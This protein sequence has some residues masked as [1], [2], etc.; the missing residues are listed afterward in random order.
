MDKIYNVG[1]IGGGVSGVVTALHLANSGIDS[2]LFE[3]KSSVV[4]GP[5]FCHL[6]AGGNLYP[7]ISD[8]ERRKLMKQSIAMARMFPQSIDQRPTFI[9]VP[10]TEKIETGIIEQR[11][12]MLVDYYT[13]LIKAD[14]ANQILGKPEEYYKTYSKEAVEKLSQ[15]PA[16]K[17]PTS[18]DDWMCNAARLI[19]LEKLKTPVFMVREYGWNMF[20][21]AAQAQLALDKSDNCAL[22]TNTYVEDIKDYRMS[23]FDFNWEIQTK[24]GVFRTKYL[25]NSSGYK[26]N[27][28]DTAINI[29]T[30][31]LVEFKAAY[32]SKWEKQ[33]G[34]LPELIFHGERG[35]PNGMAQLTPYN[36][37]YYQIHGMTNEITLFKK[38]LIIMNGKGEEERFDE[39]F[40]QKLTQGWPKEE[41]VSRT[42]NAIRFVSRFVP[43]FNSA[44][45][46][47]PPLFGAQQVVG[48]NL[49]RRV[50][51]VSFP[52]PFYARSEII[53]ASSALT[54]AH[55]IIHQVSN[56]SG[57]RGY[58]GQ[59]N[60]N[61]LVQGISKSELDAE[62]SEI[63]RQ[64]G[65]PKAMA[66]LLVE[67][68]AD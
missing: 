49:S 14:P 25:V 7:D 68:T 32:V 22:K 59:A 21:L 65:F 48:D 50:G 31:R 28:F 33:P 8:E 36:G 66:Y 44:T 67:R 18:L 53:K 46:G 52:E 9:S 39:S 63:A 24:A 23:D 40:K 17:S 12:N 6:H 58:S 56:G 29:S 30:K 57:E 34:L 47:G 13:E 11:L 61:A 20:R 1:I 62:A 43:D 51:E 2:V 60:E 4:N 42:E 45:P 41:L 54:V 64:R 38:G 3:Q 15:L 16:V 27:K 19:D 10:K 26:T 35:T 55:K 5:P 37:N